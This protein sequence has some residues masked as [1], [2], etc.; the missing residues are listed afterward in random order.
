M[1]L[2]YFMGMGKD[3]HGEQNTTTCA[4]FMFFVYVCVFPKGLCQINVIKALQD[5]ANYIEGVCWGL[6]SRPCI[7]SDVLYLWAT[8]S[9]SWLSFQRPEIHDCV[10]V[11]QQEVSVTGNAGDSAVLLGLLERDWQWVGKPNCI[12]FNKTCATPW[13]RNHCCIWKFFEN[14]E[15]YKDVWSISP[16][17]IKFKCFQAS[18]NQYKTSVINR[19]KPISRLFTSETKRKITGLLRS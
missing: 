1:G 18:W 5:S 3:R 6:N 19:L 9:P 15:M 11:S 2:R 17:C 8:L 14:R 12:P 7:C 4:H 10:C 16:N 13:I